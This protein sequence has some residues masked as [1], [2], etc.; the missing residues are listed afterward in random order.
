MIGNM[1]KDSPIRGDLFQ[2]GMVV[3]DIDEAMER[4][5][6]VFGLGPF[7]RHDTHYN[8]RY[9]DWHGVIANRN[10]FARWGDWWLEM[11]EPGQ[12][13]GNAKEWL[14]ERGEG[15]FHLGFAVDDVDAYPPQ[16]PAVFESLDT[17]TED[18]RTAVVHLDTVADLGY[19][20]ELQ[21]RKLVDWFND[22]LDK[23][24]KDPTSK[25]YVA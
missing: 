6:R 14:R 5:R 7:I 24:L 8:A 12:G 11:V 2:L 25:G 15:I 23:A 19:F 3:H 10:A 17:K 22:H 18:G 1:A 20:T 21:D 9:R 4:Y 13:E 16:W